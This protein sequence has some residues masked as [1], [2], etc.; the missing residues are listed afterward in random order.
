VT[1]FSPHV[2]APDCVIAGS[3][4]VG[5]DALVGRLAGEG[6]SARLMALGSM[7]G[8]AAARRGECDLA[9]IHLLDPA[10]G[11]YNEP[12]LTD[13]LTLVPG[14][15][16]MQGFVF[17]PGDRRFDGKTAEGAIA[18]A[19]HDPGCL[20]VNRNQGA[21]TRIIIDRLLEGQRP[22]GYWNQPKSHNAV[23]AAVAQGR[24]DWGIAIAPVAEA[25]GLAFLPIG[26]EHYDFA[27]AAGSRG[28]PAVSRFVSLLMDDETADLLRGLGFEP[29]GRA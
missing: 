29:A 12:Y 10:T 20:M 28:K 14:W 11:I 16:R 1:L 4:C 9:P 8:L 27:L 24:A 2:R 26:E 17:R 18:A 15:R 19:L 6:F 22:D 21:G 25:Y 13:G 23:A 3:H 7:G 5:L